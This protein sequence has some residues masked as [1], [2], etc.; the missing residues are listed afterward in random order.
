MVANSILT[1]IPGEK[2]V[3]ESESLKSRLGAAE[4]VMAHRVIIGAKPACFRS[5]MIE[6]ATETAA[7]S[8]V[9]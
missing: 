4:S 2:E 9:L 7:V 8:P 6:F 1:T 3:L 5:Q